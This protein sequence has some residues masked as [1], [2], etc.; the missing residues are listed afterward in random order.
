V[1]TIGGTIEKFI[2]PNQGPNGTLPCTNNW[3]VL[4]YEKDGGEG[5]V[6][7]TSLNLEPDTKQY[8]SNSILKLFPES[9]STLPGADHYDYCDNA[10]KESALKGRFF[11]C[12]GRDASVD[13]E[14]SGNA[15][16]W[17]NN[18]TQILLYSAEAFNLPTE[19][20]TFFED[21]FRHPI[22][23]II[24]FFTGNPLASSFDFVRDLSDF[25]KIY[26]SVLG[27]TNTKKI[28]GAIE[29]IGANQ[30]MIIRYENLG[31]NITKEPYASMLGCG[32]PFEVNICDYSPNTLSSAYATKSTNKFDLFDEL[33]TRT[34]L[35]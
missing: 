16:L 25:N 26:T 20:P 23:T 9:S 17:F 29:T 6:I 28:M 33:T 21:F 35:K 27:S 19:A 30:T 18:S 32:N 34:R 13:S 15:K 22:L 24:E 7:G 14:G 2:C 4:R 3:C 8:I 12:A 1:Q 31:I 10:T 11:G 5:V